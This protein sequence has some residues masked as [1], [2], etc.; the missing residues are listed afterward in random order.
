MNR[1]RESRLSFI[2]L[3]SGCGGFD[4][5]FTSA[6]FSCTAAFDH[7]ALAL[8]HHREY[9]RSTTH[10]EDL[11]S[12]VLRPECLSPVDVVIAGPPCQGFSTAGCRRVDDPRN[13]L[14]I[15]AGNIIRQIRPKV[16]VVENVPGVT[17]GA[18]RKYW[19]ELAALLRAIGYQTTTL[20]CRVSAFGVPQLRTRLILVGWNTGELVTLALKEMTQSVLRDALAGL[21]VAANHHPALLEP[22]SQTARIAA[23]IK[24]G[25]K[26][27]NVR[28]GPNAVHTWD[29][30]AVFGV[31]TIRQREVLEA[32]L[33]LRR[34]LRSREHGDAD[35]VTLQS[36]SQMVGRDVTSDISSLVR[37]GFLKKVRKRYDLTH[38]FNGKY[39]RLRWD[40][41]SP[42]VDTRFGNP[43]FFLYPDE[44]RGFTVREAARIQGFPDDFVFS[45]PL[46]SQFRMVGNAVP[47]PIGA[48][49]AQVVRTAFFD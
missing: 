36:I 20:K 3:F 38:S 23:H 18:H 29:M 24:P 49:I 10:C 40:R 19:D 42:A 22:N 44:N 1:G 15:A 5:G 34:R 35:P 30:P 8:Q 48:T 2:S 47:P 9:L 11:T 46:T 17:Y 13:H 32:V 33:K 6:G 4:L 16:C 39:R 43:R 14:L 28:G 31:T 41:P 21:T 45:G 37:T 26:L 25:Q 27:S 12:G 7:D